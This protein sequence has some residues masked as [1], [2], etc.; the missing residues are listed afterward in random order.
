MTNKEYLSAF[1]YQKKTGYPFKLCEHILKRLNFPQGKLL[2]VGCGTEEHMEA[3]RDL[4]LEVWGVDNIKHESDTVKMCDLSKDKIPFSSNY[5]DVVFTKS[6]LEH[7]KP[8]ENSLKEIKRVLKKSGVVIIMVPD[9]RSQYRNYYDG[10]DHV[11]PF[12]IRGLRD[13]MNHIGFRN[14]TCEYFYQLP[15]VWDSDIAKVIPKVVSLL[16]DKLKW[17][18]E[19]NHRKL[20]R[21]SKEKMLLGV[22]YV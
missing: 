2:D 18:D 4:G 16:P 19:Y 12:T 22:G 15:F 10:Y 7:L 1:Y 13:L 20:I 8:V 11:T 3:F 21:F 17:K 6:C 9:W 5:F 14:V